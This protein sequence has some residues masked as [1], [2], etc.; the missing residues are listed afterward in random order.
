MLNINLTKKCMAIL[1]AGIILS[2][3]SFM[4]PRV[5][6]TKDPMHGVTISEKTEDIDWNSIAK[7]YDFVLLNAGDGITDDTKFEEYYQKARDKKLDVGV[8]V[9]NDIS[10]YYNNSPSDI[11]KYAERRYSHVKISQ[12]IGKN[13]SYPVYLRIDYGDIPIDVALPKEHAN[14]LF[15]RY[16]M[17]MNHNKFIPGVYATEEVY[18]YLKEN[19]NNFDERFAHVIATKE[20]INE[21]KDDV[22]VKMLSSDGV[23]E[24]IEEEPTQEITKE[25]KIKAAPLSN[26]IEEVSLNT[27]YNDRS[28]AKIPVILLSLDALAC[29]GIQGS[30]R[31]QR[32]K[33]EAL[34]RKVN[35]NPVERIIVEVENCND[36]RENYKMK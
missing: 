3:K 17:I 1:T 20:E 16:A 24:E 26:K 11:T 35:E 13:I 8:F 10:T 12:L 29:L 7:K 5:V 21:L 2:S 23:E 15:D 22:E 36:L 30:V 9:V 32:K 33:R 6:E 25:T 34:L 18:E 27:N 14:R 31:K 4:E 28:R 19:V